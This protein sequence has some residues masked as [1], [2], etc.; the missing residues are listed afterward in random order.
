MANGRRAVF[1]HLF[2]D[3]DSTDPKQRLARIRKDRSILDFVTQSTAR[4]L[5]GLGPSDRGKL[6]QYLDAVR[7]VERRIQKAEEQ[8]SRELPT[9]ER[10]LGVPAEFGEHA[11]LMYDLQ[12]LAYQ[13]DLTRVT[14][15][16]I[17][18]EQT[19]RAYG[20]IGIPD[21]HHSVTHHGGDAQ[22]IAKVIKINIYHMQTFAYFLEKLRSTPDGDGSLL[23]H[24]MI[25]YGGGLSDG[26]MHS[27]ENLPILLIG[28]GAD[29]IKGGRHIRCPKDTPL[30]NLYVTM[31]DMLGVPVERVGSSTGKLEL[32]SVV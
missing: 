26:N 15:F 3:S 4:L 2:G 6:T 24:S 12:V 29:R 30:P 20:E 16:M 18:H 25:L 21:S 32:H 22:K 5:T 17:G 14:T 1:E 10:P 23:D 28:G 9:L 8:S 27:H 31:L 19:N 13:C 11:K 7:D